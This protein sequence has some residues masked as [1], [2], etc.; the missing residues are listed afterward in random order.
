MRLVEWQFDLVSP[1]EILSHSIAGRLEDRER[2]AWSP[3]SNNL[4]TRIACSLVCLCSFWILASA[5]A[6]TENRNW[7]QWRG[8]NRDGIS[9]IKLPESLQDDSL[10][11]IWSTPLSPSYSGPI[12][13]DDMVFVTETVDSAFETVQALRRSDGTN[14]WTAKWKGAMKVPFFA[15]ANGSWIRATP[16]YSNGKLFVAG[17]RDV[18]VCLDAKNGKE[19]WKVDFPGQT[20]SKL[21]SFGFVCSP[22]VDGEF[23]YVQAGGAFTKLAAKDG[24]IVWQTLKDGGGM[25]GSAFSSPVIATIAGVRQAVV[26]TRNELCGVELETGKPLWKIAV[27][28]FRG[29]NIL[30]PSLY[31]DGIFTSTYGGTTQLFNVATAGETGALTVNQKWSTPAQGYMTSPVIVADHAYIHLRNQRFACFDLKTG[32]EKWRSETYGKYASL[33]AAGDKILA[34]DQRGDLLMIK[35]NPMQFELIDKRKVADDSWAHV[36][37]TQDDVVVRDLKKVTLFKWVK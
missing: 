11:E 5:E 32:D 25:G 13:V 4:K 23:V 34:L 22:L 8:P 27:K 19:I 9:K 2:K 26:L 20:K 36:A 10:T 18:V 1:L 6:Q 31:G 17:I 35:A 16:A 33:V 21:P 29:M 24:S 3:I 15:A 37:V 14:V 7:S 12:V 30:T 28:A